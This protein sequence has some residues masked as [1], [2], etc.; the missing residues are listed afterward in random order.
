MGFIFQVVE[1]NMVDLGTVYYGPLI[2]TSAKMFHPHA[3]YDAESLGIFSAWGFIFFFFV[4]LIYFVFI[5]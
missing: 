3:T 2:L 4:L 1:T 5:F